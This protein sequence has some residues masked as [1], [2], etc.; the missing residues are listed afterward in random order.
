VFLIFNYRHNH[1]QIMNK[2]IAKTFAL[3]AA[4][5]FPLA[6]FAEQKEGQAWCWG[7]GRNG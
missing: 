4:C 3:G 2:R 1:F 7:F 5:L 6:F